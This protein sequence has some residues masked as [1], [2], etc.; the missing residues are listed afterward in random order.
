MREVDVLF[1][2][3]K[4]LTE[5]INSSSRIELGYERTSGDFCRLFTRLVRFGV[6]WYL[7]YGNTLENAG[8]TFIM[9]EGG[10]FFGPYTMREP[11]RKVELTYNVDLDL[12]GTMGWRERSGGRR[13]L[14]TSQV[15]EGWIK[16]LLESEHRRAS[17]DD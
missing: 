4:R 17:R 16:M 14:T 12:S 7:M 9:T 15:A 5:Q 3:L 11:D 1:G 10:A 2:E 13:F 8:L 6:T